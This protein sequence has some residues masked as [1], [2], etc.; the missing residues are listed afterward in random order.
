MG[1]RKTAS[2][3]RTSSVT[4]WSIMICRNRRPAMTDRAR[5]AREL[6]RLIECTE[7]D[8]AIYVA[9]F[10]K[11]SDGQFPTTKEICDFLEANDVRHNIN[12]SRLQG[13][14]NKDKRVSAPRGKPV[15]VGARELSRVADQFPEFQESAPPK[16]EDTLL[17]LSDFE[18]SRRYLKAIAC[19][20]NGTYQFSFFDACAVMMRRLAEV[21]II[22]AYTS[23]GLDTNIRDSDGNLKMMNGLINALKS[24]QPFRLSRNAPQYLDHL[25]TLGDTA[26]HSRN[27]I[28][29]KKDIDDFSQKYRML[30]E[31]LRN[32]A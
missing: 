4:T 15:S 10:L 17:V 24:G 19:Q 6:S 32:L 2:L 5:F 9:W 1:L 21:L 31:E 13:R 29:K 14:L 26:A 11:E 18:D 30:I 12:R 3:S 28:T 20:V 7:V 23:K 22:D 16:V 27:Y 25:K 8:L